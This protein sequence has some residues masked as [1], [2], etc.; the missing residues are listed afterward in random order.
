MDT[1][2]VVSV[3]DSGAPAQMAHLCFLI[4]TLK[5]ALY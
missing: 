2:A 5:H 3:R 1:R 4:N